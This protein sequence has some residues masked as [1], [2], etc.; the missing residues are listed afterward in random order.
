MAIVKR[1]FISNL[2]GKDFYGDI[3]QIARIIVAIGTCIF[4]LLLLLT[5]F[6]H[7]GFLS[8]LVNLLV[9]V[10]P[11]FIVYV[12]A[13]IIVL[14][15]EVD[16]DEPE[17]NFWE[18]S[19]KQSK[20]IVYQLTIVWGA[21]LIILGIGAI[22]T[23]NEYKNKYSFECNT[24]LVDH[25]AKIYHLEWVID[26]EEAKQANH[27]EKMKGYQIDKSYSLCEWCESCAEDDE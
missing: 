20:P 9:G 21:I 15:I 13:F 24:F 16:V 4:T 8:Y 2:L 14:D 17:R 26:C 1:S 6:F 10:S 19:A 18:E 25:K 27:L 23:G 7:S 3:K 5:N 11:F 22:Y 12:A